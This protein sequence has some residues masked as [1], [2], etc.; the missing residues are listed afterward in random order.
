VKLNI[1]YWE[2]AIAQVRRL[3]KSQFYA[4]IYG[5]AKAKVWF[6]D[7]MGMLLMGGEL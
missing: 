4:V 5:N 2:M 7:A 6:D 1:Y 3:N